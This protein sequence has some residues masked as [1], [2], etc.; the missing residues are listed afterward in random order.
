LTGR[1]LHSKL[2]SIVHP[3]KIIASAIHATGS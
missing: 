3:D 2:L 1:Q